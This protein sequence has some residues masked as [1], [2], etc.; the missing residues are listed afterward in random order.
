MKAKVI[1]ENGETTIIITP[2]NAFDTD[3]IEKLHSRKESFTISTTTDADYGYG[4]WSK[5]RIE[6]SIKEV[7]P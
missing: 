2:E 1:I 4:S 7:R 3:V 5:H 6:L